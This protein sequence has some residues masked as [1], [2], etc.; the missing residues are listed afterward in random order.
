VAAADDSGEVR[1]AEV[2]LVGKLRSHIPEAVGLLL[3]R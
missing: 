2:R 3:L 1:A